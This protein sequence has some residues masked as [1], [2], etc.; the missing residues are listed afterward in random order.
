[1][2]TIT[3][4]SSG[5]LSF[6]PG[7]VAAALANLISKR[8][9]RYGVRIFTRKTRRIYNIWFCVYDERVSVCSFQKLKKVETS[10]RD[11]LCIF[12][13]LEFVVVEC[14]YYVIYS[15]RF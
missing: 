5:E 1:M 9:N 15:V 12:R 7:P 4:E 8:K 3:R 10:F 14:T 13:M 11:V 2:C 6:V